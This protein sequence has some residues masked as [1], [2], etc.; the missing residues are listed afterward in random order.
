MPIHG[1]LSFPFVP[2]RPNLTLSLDLNPNLN[3]LFILV[4]KCCGSLVLA[5]TR[6]AFNYH[7]EVSHLH[8]MVCSVK[9][10]L[11]GIALELGG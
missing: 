2:H 1:Y 10:L 4:L 7:T 6:L 9:L 3:P 8:V 5:G 11:P